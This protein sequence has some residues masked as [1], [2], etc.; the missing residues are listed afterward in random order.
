[1]SDAQAKLF[2]QTTLTQWDMQ[3]IHVSCYY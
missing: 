3:I 2:T 1:M